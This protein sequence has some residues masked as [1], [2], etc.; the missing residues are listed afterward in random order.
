M[1]R[2]L[3]TG[4]HAGIR[5]TVP[6]LQQNPAVAGCNGASVLLQAPSGDAIRSRS[7]IHRQAAELCTCLAV[8]QD[9]FQDAASAQCKSACLKHGFHQCRFESHKIKKGTRTHC[10]PNP[11]PTS[12]SIFAKPNFELLSDRFKFV[13][14][15]EFIF[16][17][18]KFLDHRVFKLLLRVDCTCL[19]RKS[20][21]SLKNKLQ[22]KI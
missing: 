1:Q 3:E 21:F 15:Q 14:D 12:I 17:I 7:S 11:A 13:S 2:G 5:N 16:T 9:H 6:G 19:L 8:G 20:S 10:Q 18:Q 22:L 4:Q